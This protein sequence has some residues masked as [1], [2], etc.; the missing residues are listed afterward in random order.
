MTYTYKFAIRM[1]ASKMTPGL[2]K[3][4]AD[5]NR[6]FKDFTG[7]DIKLDADLVVSTISM[8]TDVPCT[9]EVI[10]QIR[11]HAEDIYNKDIPGKNITLK[12]IFDV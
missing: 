2:G 1:E 3:L 5:I 11:K 9:P 4:F 12:Q 7:D 10:E 8:T 6:N